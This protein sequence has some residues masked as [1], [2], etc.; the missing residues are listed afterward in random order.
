MRNLKAILIVLLCL[1]G[2]HVQAQ[3]LEIKGLVTSS[4]DKQPLIGATV[5]VK[6]VP[7]RGVVTDMD[8][9]Y[10]LKIE[11]SD[12]IL[13]ISYIGMKSSEVK[14][15]K[16]GVLNVVLQPESLN[17]D[18]V[19]VTGY[20]N[21]SKSSFTG[22][23]NTLRADMLKNVPVL[24]VE[25]KLQGMTTGV[26]ITSGSGQPGA[27]QSIRIRGMGSFNASR[28]AGGCSKQRRRNHRLSVLP[29][30]SWRNPSRQYR[31]RHREWAWGSFSERQP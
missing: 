14:V 31:H 18:E 21:F 28:L 26:N 19:V 8:G 3:Q 27:N 1:C 16:N 6:G 10:T 11:P 4:E 24:S 2:I 25:Q 30:F 5:A 9:R 22:S 20:G 29:R 17:L 7:G 12:K 13:V 23:A 15:P